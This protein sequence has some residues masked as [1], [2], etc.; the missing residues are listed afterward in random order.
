MGVRLEV[1]KLYKTLSGKYVRIIESDGAGRKPFKG[2][3]VNETEIIRYFRNG[4]Y[5]NASRIKGGH[6][7]DILVEIPDS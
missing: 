1:G 3:I 7:L 4:S 5:S 6:P 2:Q